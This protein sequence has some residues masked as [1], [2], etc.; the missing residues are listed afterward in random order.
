MS[1]FEFCSLSENNFNL[2][3]E[4]FLHIFF[5]WWSG[6]I[7]SSALGRKLTN[8]VRV[9]RPCWGVRGGGGFSSAPLYKTGPVKREQWNSSRAKSH[10]AHFSV[11]AAEAPQVSDSFLLCRPR[12]CC[13]YHIATCFSFLLR[14]QKLQDERRLLPGWTP[15]HHQRA[16]Q[17]AGGG[18]GH[19]PHVRWSH[20]DSNFFF[21]KKNTFLVIL[22]FLFL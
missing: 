18:P 6:R 11:P 5:N 2:H 20:P 21:M 16:Q 14:K 13:V 15:A 3:E 1:T 12:S 4:F 17:L 22:M 7:C 10:L 9:M 19:Q 8:G